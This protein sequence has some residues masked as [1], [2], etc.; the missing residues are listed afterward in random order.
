MKERWTRRIE[1]SQQFRV[2]KLYTCK[3]QKQSAPY[4]QIQ[5]G[6]SYHDSHPSTATARYVRARNHFRSSNHGCGLEHWPQIRHGTTPNIQSSWRSGAMM[7][8]M[9]ILTTMWRRRRQ[10]QLLMDLRKVAAF[11]SLSSRHLRWS[12]STKMCI[13][14][15]SRVFTR[16]RRCSQFLRERTYHQD[17]PGIKHFNDLRILQENDSDAKCT[18]TIE[19]SYISFVKPSVSSGPRSDGLSPKQIV[20]HICKEALFADQLKLYPEQ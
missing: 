14:L 10:L 11:D 8:E 7:E 17:H 6:F 15:C 1:Y 2:R 12:C 3:N 4:K 5:T 20:F 18:V 13:K 19:N 9:Q 16:L